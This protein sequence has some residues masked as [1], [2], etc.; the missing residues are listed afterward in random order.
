M[1]HRQI[2]SEGTGFKLDFSHSSLRY[3]FDKS[4]KGNDK[5]IVCHTSHIHIARTF[6]EGFLRLHFFVA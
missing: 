4:L 5:E 1:L 3:I 2:G 6:R